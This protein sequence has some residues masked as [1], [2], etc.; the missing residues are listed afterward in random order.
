M[1]GL[2]PGLDESR[3]PRTEGS[4]IPNGRRRVHPGS[5]RRNVG[6]METLS[7][8][9]PAMGVAEVQSSCGGRS[10]RNS[11][12]R[13][14]IR[15]A[16][17]SDEV[18]LEDLRRRAYADLF[19]ATWGGWD[20]ARHSRQFSGSIK[21]GNISIIE[22]EPR[23][24][25]ERAPGRDFQHRCPGT[26]RPPH[27]WPEE[28]LCLATSQVSRPLRVVGCRSSEHRWSRALDFRAPCCFRT[29][30]TDL[31]SGLP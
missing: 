3:W 10:V 1:N 20:E 22:V 30:A 2:Y 11:N 17:S 5:V 9:A 21:R 13:Y 26:G 19:D 4:R 16:T 28:R 12:V 29:V 24:R 31:L 18:W 8:S 27:R 15:D 6:T 14:R 25:H 7:A 23:S